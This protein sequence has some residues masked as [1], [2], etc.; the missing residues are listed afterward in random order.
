MKVSELLA[1]ATP[2]PVTPCRCTHEF[3]RHEGDTGGHCM[4]CGCLEFNECDNAEP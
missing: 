1:K 3:I 2:Q 4:D